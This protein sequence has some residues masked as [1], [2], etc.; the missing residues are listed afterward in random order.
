M[1][2]ITEKQINAAAAVTQRKVFI[3]LFINIFLLS[4][5]TSLISAEKSGLI[6]EISSFTAK[7]RSAIEKI[8]AKLYNK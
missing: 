7:I 2:D 5:F 6:P 8:K 1:A 3:F 4:V